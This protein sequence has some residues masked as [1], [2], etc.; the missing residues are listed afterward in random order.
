MG[1]RQFNQCSLA[2]QNRRL[3]IC[4]KA[5]IDL[6]LNFIDQIWVLWWGV[7][8]LI[9]LKICSSF[10]MRETP[11][12]LFSKVREF[13]KD[14]YFICYHF[15]TKNCQIMEIPSKFSKFP[16]TEWFLLKF[17]KLQI[18]YCNT[19]VTLQSYFKFRLLLMFGNATFHISVIK[20]GCKLTRLL[21]NLNLTSVTTIVRHLKL[22]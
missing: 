14:Y 6:V 8:V 13:G 7:I 15:Y 11:C 17:V 10:V 3:V 19:V 21:V 12:C 20:R 5:L 18:L 2:W 4:N 16:V 9:L 22:F 1:I